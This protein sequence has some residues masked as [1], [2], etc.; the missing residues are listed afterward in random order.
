[1][2]A[3]GADRLA[4]TAIETLVHLLIEQRIEQVEAIVGDRAHQPEPSSRRRHL[5]AGK[6]VGRARRQAHPTMNARSQQIV[7]GDIR[8]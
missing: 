5:L 2:H 7:L 1:M 8:P 4:S 6:P 3:G